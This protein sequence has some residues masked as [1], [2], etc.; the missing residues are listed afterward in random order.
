MGE[1]ERQIK[2]DKKVEIMIEMI[3]KRALRDRG[4][5]R[6]VRREWQS[7][8]REN[9]QTKTDTEVV[10]D[11]ESDWRKNN[12]AQRPQRTKTKTQ[13]YRPWQRWCRECVTN[14]TK[15]KAKRERERDRERE[16]YFYCLHL[17]YEESQSKQ[18]GAE[19]ISKSCEIWDGEVIRI[20]S[21]LPQIMN[22]P[23][24]DVQQQCNLKKKN[25]KFIFHSETNEE[26]GLS[27][28]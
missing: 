18:P 19:K 11:Q 8:R 22:H 13:G 20:V 5:K 16:V 1:N 21:S 23:H 27:F 2:D 17:Q 10:Q 25:F 7:Q 26:L 14:K 28:T 12:T 24:W 9:T 4:R 6:D 15:T 3:A